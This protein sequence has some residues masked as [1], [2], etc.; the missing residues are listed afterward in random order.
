VPFLSERTTELA[1]GLSLSGG[2][3]ARVALARALYSKAQLV[4]LDDVLSAVDSATTAHLLRHCIGGTL[5][6]G[7]T[8]LLVTHYV[9][10]CARSNACARVVLLEDG[11]VSKSGSPTD[12]LGRDL[13]EQ[14]MGDE[15]VGA[16][17]SKKER[18]D[19]PEAD[20]TG[21]DDES[22][23]GL[24]ISYAVYLRYLKQMGGPLFWLPYLVIN[25]AA[26]LLMIG[27]NGFVGRWVS[28]SDQE[29]REGFYFGIYAG[30]QVRRPLDSYTIPDARQ[31]GTGVTLTAMYLWLIFGAVRASRRLHSAVLTSIFN[32]PVR[33][34]DKT[35]L[36]RLINRMSKGARPS[37]PSPAAG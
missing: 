2:Q 15:A 7:R 1:Q 23:G 5:L 29:D 10:L 33:F 8:V 6:K 37:A 16:E 35:P 4:L 24:S 14:A 12:V 34:F 21:E 28:A 27:Q 11:R 9:E 22:T 30:L 13:A 31:V 36:A 3:K 20:Q 18:D 26:H 25:V 32:A 17:V 19:K